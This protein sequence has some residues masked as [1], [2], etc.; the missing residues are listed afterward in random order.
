[1]NAKIC[2]IK[3]NKI[4]VI[5]AAIVLF[6]L[7]ILRIRYGV[8]ITDT[9]YSYGNFENFSSMEGMWVIA[10]YLANVVGHFFT[11]LPFGHTMLGMNFYTGLVISAILLFSFFFL[12]K[13]FP[14][15]IVFIGELLAFFLCW[16]PSA[17]LYNYLTYL[18]MT[19]ALAYIYHGLI[20][21]K[22]WYLVVAGIFLGM[23]VFVRIPN[24]VEMGF[25][26][27]IWY[28][29]FS[30]K[31]GWKT[32][33]IHTFLCIAGYLIGIGSL[34]FV[35]I[36]QY[37]WLQLKGMINSLV[38][39]GNEISG[40]GPLSMV[41]HIA[42]DY[43]QHLRFLWIAVLCLFL[44]QVLYSKFKNRLMQIIICIIG[45]GIFAGVF[46]FYYRM[47][48]FSYNQYNDYTSIFFWAMMFLVI[49]ITVDV[50]FLVR[51][52]SSRESKLLAMFSL[53]IL[54]LT[55]LG[56]NNSVYPNF[57]NLFIVAPVTFYGLYCFVFQKKN[58]KKLLPLQVSLFAVL[59]ILMVQCCMFK[60]IF[61]F[62]DAGLTKELNTI[63]T[64][65]EV[66][67]GMVTTKEQAEMIADLTAYIQAENLQE[68]KVVIFGYA[69]GISY[70]LHMQPA[71]SSTWPD[72]DSYSKE[73]FTSSL[74]QAD[75]PLVFI[76]L[77]KYPDVVSYRGNTGDEK[78]AIMANYLL[79][80]QYEVIYQDDNFEI[81]DMR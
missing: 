9:G 70:F 8:D 66:T 41:K 7:P 57:N 10:T 37:G 73:E 31:K 76:Y 45:G 47:K 44:V 67:K 11:L 4:W 35:I 75:N 29:A 60:I 53:L 59:L 34:M 15:W 24:L 1:M 72:L 58:R 46:Y 3:N 40:Y 50:A 62:R 49:S 81:Y 23:N 42:L 69:P 14:T 52:D 28:D 68:R 32:G 65:N 25:I 6:V 48:L 55:P 21:N 5:L 26:L 36:F 64:K 13:I 74:S 18:F 16:C 2:R 20:H 61:T 51:K 63:I 79:M 22:K 38:D 78:A 30:Q 19:I 43:F 33:I 54:I 71:I 12:R 17:I 56:S 77:K 27:A 80:Q 39:V